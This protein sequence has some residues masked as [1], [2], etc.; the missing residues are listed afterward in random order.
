[1]AP[2]TSEFVRQ[3]F[4]EFFRARRHM[5]IHGAS[6]LAK[7]DPTLLFVNSGMAPLKDYFTGVRRPPAP[8]LTNIQPCIR[9]IDIDDIG[10]RHHLSFFEMM[11]SWSIGEYFKDRAVELAYELLTEGFGFDPNQLYVTVFEGDEALGVPADEESAA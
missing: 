6:V 8:N 11:G 5:Q 7:D 2:V 9:T 3:T 10:D 1:M 4:L